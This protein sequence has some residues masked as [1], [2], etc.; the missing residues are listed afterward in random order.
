[1]KL[2]QQ[3]DNDAVIKNQ[4]Y[5]TNYNFDLFSN[6]TFYLKDSINGDQIEQFE[7]RN[8]YGYNGSYTKNNYFGSVK[9]S[10]EAGIQLRYDDVGTI[11]LSHT[12]K[13]FGLID[14]PALGQI[15][16]FNGAAYLDETLKFGGKL[17]INA[18]VRYDQFRFGY[19][20]K[21][22]SVYNHKVQTKG[23]ASPKFS[24]FYNITR[25]FQ[26]YAKAGTGFH[27][28]DTRVA[29]AQN[30]QKILPRALGSDLGIII[31]PVKNLWIN[32][33]VWI[34]DLEQEFIYVGDDAVV[35]AG[36]YTR[37]YGADFSARYQLLK[38]LFIDT[39]VNYTIPRTLNV[40]TSQSYI[41]LAPTFTSIG[42][43]SAIFRNGLQTSLRYRWVGDRP[44][45]ETN[46]VI[47]MGYKVI[48]LVVNYKRPKYA[49]GF[50]V[51]N[52]L[53]TTWNEAQ[54]DTES[55]LK[56]ETAPVSE[57]HFT[58][59]TPFFLKGSLTYYF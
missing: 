1:M 9:L 45:N 31:K 25:N 10:S 6:F 22:D 5:Y 50:S 40:E 34:I 17:T 4:V 53:N 16:Q 43:I 8:M 15:S 32:A 46:T 58:P 30:G 24:L 36:G 26:L 37:R 56:N 19:V 21:L 29:V 23:I 47:A 28:N 27:S 2:V 44:A 48:D 14:R 11:G 39:D 41:P 52:L 42:G 20:N 35:E 57:L 51:E 49:V 59:G 18:A 12:K 54:F 38:W 3:L 13:R 7:G 33:A 55:R